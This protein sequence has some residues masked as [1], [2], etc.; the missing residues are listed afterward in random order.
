MSLIANILSFT[1]TILIALFCILNIKSVDI[2]FSP[3]H[4]PISLPLYAVVLS[5]LALGFIIGACTLWVNS[6]TLRKARK[7]QRKQI[8]VLEKELSKPAVSNT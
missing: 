1:L 5:S 4:D 6:G 3:L 2:I 7:Q 8:K